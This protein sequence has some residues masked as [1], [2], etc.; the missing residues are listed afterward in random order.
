[1]AEVDNV[2]LAV[3][4]VALLV[5]FSQ[6]LAQLFST[7]EGYRR[8]Q[9]SVIG[10]WAQYSH[11]RWRETEWRFETIAVTPEFLLA[12]YSPKSSEQDSSNHDEKNYPELQSP[13][14]TQNADV[15]AVEYARQL[16]DK[17]RDSFFHSVLKGPFLYI[18]RIYAKAASPI[19]HKKIPEGDKLL[20]HSSFAE[21]HR[22][23]P[24][25]ELVCWIALLQQLHRDSKQCIQDIKNVDLKNWEKSL[26]LS[27]ETTSSTKRSTT[28]PAIRFKQRSWDFMP[29]EVVRPFASTTVS[30]IAILALRMGMTWRTFQPNLNKLEAEGGQRI[31]A[32]TTIRGLGM[33]LQFQRMAANRDHLKHTQRRQFG[34]INS[35]TQGEGHTQPA[36]SKSS[37][38]MKGHL[39]YTPEADRMWFGILVGNPEI[40]DLCDLEF[41]IG[42]LNNVYKTMDALDPTKKATACLQGMQNEKVLFGFKDII[43]MVAPWMRQPNSRINRVPKVAPS[44][45]GS[46]YF[47]D[48]FLVF[49]ARLQGHPNPTN[50]MRGVL[51]RWED[52]RAWNPEWDGISP[53]PELRPLGFLDLV[54]EC[55]HETTAYFQKIKARLP[56]LDLVKAHLSRAPF[57]KKEAKERIRNYDAN[58]PFRRNRTSVPNV[59]ERHDWSPESMHVYWD[60]VVH[61]QRALKKQTDGDAALVE[62]AWVMLMFRAF[63]WQ[64]GHHFHR[65]QDPLPAIFYGSQMPVYIG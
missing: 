52:L 31:L 4:L 7:A 27:E 44:V 53:N 32:S 59:D 14:L 56:Y 38:E 50:D 51:K 37:P 10:E 3:A 11:R 15:S 2:A 45:G 39:V 1:M 61:H 12:P 21:K 30:D 19:R 41:H 63:L 54:E 22:Q 6:L 34:D 33:L 23:D 47:H 8:C 65:H 36:N 46:T 29:S 5:T 25:S 43:P 64:R 26:L 35:A 55:Y 24:K 42:N 18:G 13:P 28:W 20:L 49:H 62:E 17:R 48:R 9:E 57:A 58:A 40:E 60:Y 16:T